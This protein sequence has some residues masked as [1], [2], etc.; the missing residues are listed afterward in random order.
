MDI[1][2]CIQEM[3][4]F[5]QSR[6]KFL[7]EQKSDPNS[8]F[9]IVQE[10]EDMFSHP[11][12]EILYQERILQEDPL[13]KEE[14]TEVSLG[15]FMLDLENYVPARINFLA[16]NDR[17]EDALSLAVEFEEYFE[18]KEKLVFIPKL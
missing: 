8:A 5:A 17:Y 11:E 18:Q 9:A 6:I 13:S 16:D 12:H 3:E 15:E 2:E 1:Q 10:F 4:D 7:V 14:L